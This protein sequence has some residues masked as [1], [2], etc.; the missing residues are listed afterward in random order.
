MS[1][2]PPKAD[3]RAD[4]VDVRF[5]P[6]ADIAPSADYTH[7]ITYWR[8]GMPLMRCATNYFSGH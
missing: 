2:L 3:I 4:I 7:G 5:V 8:L 6:R 1:A